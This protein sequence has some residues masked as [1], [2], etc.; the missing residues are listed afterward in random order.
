MN[1]FGLRKPESL[2]A[3]LNLERHTVLVKFFEL[4]GFGLSRGFEIAVFL[5][6]CNNLDH[7]NS[8]KVLNR[9]AF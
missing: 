8:V 3:V 7:C 1:L 6:L 4:K 5:I 2:T 9:E